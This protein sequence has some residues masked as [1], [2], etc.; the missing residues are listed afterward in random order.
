MNAPPSGTAGGL[1]VRA[2]IAIAIVAAGAFAL[3]AWHV[4]HGLPDFLEE[5][6]PFRLAIG[7]WG[8][9]TGRV[10]WNPH[11]FHYPSLAIYLQLLLQQA[12][13][14]LGRLTGRYAGPDDYLLAYLTDPTPMV[15]A[16]RLLQMAFD[17]AAVVGA[18]RLGERLRPGA[19]FLAA[20]VAAVSPTL[21]RTS[22][23][24]YTD[25][26][27]GALAVWSLE[28]MLAW[29]ERG[30]RVRLA[31]AAVLA[32]L[33]TGAK[34]PA[35]ILLA[36]LAWVAW[37]R[38]GARAWRPWLAAAA[39]ALAAFAL[40]TPFALLDAASFA[41]D[42]AF[43][44]LHAETG[45]FGSFAR[46]GLGYH[47]RNLAANLGWPGVILLA[48]SLAGTA[49]APRRHGAGTALW[50]A[51]LLFGLPIA[52]ARIA[53]E[54]YLAPIVP[55]AAALAAAAAWGLP[56]LAPAAARGEV[57]AIA[58]ALLF[59]PPAVA[60]WSAVGAEADRTRTEA[61]RWCEAHLGPDQVMVQEGY[62]VVLPTPVDRIDVVSGRV[63]AAA[64]EAARRR[65]DALRL[66]RVVDLPLL[67][68]GRCSS[69]VVPAHGPPVE[70]DIF[71][72]A[73]D[74]NR[75]FYD[76][77]LV[78]AADF[79]LTSS[80]VRGRFEADTGRY[81]VEHALYRRLDRAAEVAATFRPRPSDEGPAIT[82]YRLGTTA[83]AELD[84]AGALEPLWWAT[85]IPDAYRRAAT[86]L[87][88]APPPGDS[89]RVTALLDARGQPSPWV[90]SLAPVH[91]T[92]VRP[93]A[94]AMALELIGAGHPGAA[95]RFA[96]SNVTMAPGDEEACLVLAT[97]DERLGDWPAARATVERGLAAHAASAPPPGLLLEYAETLAHTG[98]PAAARAA[99]ERVIA[100][101][102]RGS[103]LDRSAHA[104]LEALEA[105]PR[106]AR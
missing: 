59:S 85:Q 77:R 67:V 96:T 17:A 5:A 54:R 7:M 2:R 35:A 39:L 14:G 45:H 32:G 69:R 72:R 9:E 51:L 88:A 91:E 15:I 49:A 60:G 83:R 93:F 98:E 46:S 21:I 70:L 13:C 3:R 78:A 50:I 41:R 90:L 65:Y 82:I 27:S 80:A 68:S 1:P 37:E 20:T 16:G 87:L 42:I 31:A 71:P 52:L 104:K 103:P 100:T 63:Y 92:Y 38:E 44:R 43:E 66:H 26:I 61:R 6:L 40:T 101:V 106:P 55:I 53:A 33:A 22:Q 56:A 73:A 62:G 97:C 34:Y 58:F 105:R 24:I 23:A 89:V 84:S 76:P 57:G 12:S 10:D 4:G 36:P 102:D 64:S 74:F 8:W 94:R 30:G 19:G 86:A 95:R 29:R 79:V 47:V 18:A 99:L 25:T 11:Q 75:V 28:R 81:A 48:L